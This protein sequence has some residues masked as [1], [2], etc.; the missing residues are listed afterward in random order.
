MPPRDEQEREAR[1]QQI[2]DAALEVFASKGFERATNKDIAQAANIKSPGLIY[3][4]FKDKFDLLRNIVLQRAPAIQLL[5]HADDLMEL[6]PREA[7]EGAMREI[8][9]IPSFSRYAAFVDGRMAGSASIRL[10]AGLAQLAG[11]ATLPEFRR[12]GIQ[13]AFLRRRLSDAVAAGCDIALITTQPGS[14]SQENADR[15]GFSLLYSRAVMV[16][17]PS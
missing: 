15:Q 16:R 17:A 8:S 10:D 13:T 14:K 1:R 2:M 7:L 9:E 5:S 11:A 4:Y 3:H 6:P 12:R